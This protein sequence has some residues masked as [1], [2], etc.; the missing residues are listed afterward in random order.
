MGRS[1]GGTACFA[2]ST[3]GATATEAPPQREAPTPFPKDKL[4]KPEMERL[5]R[6]LPNEGE[7]VAEEDVEEL[8]EAMEDL[9]Y[10][11]ETDQQWVR[12]PMRIADARKN[13]YNFGLY[14]FTRGLL[15]VMAQSEEPD[16][17]EVAVDL[18][19][20]LL[21]DGVTQTRLEI[22]FVCE[23]N[24]IP[25]LAK[26]A[27]ETM[28]QSAIESLDRIISNGPPQV[29]PSV[30]KAGVIDIGIDVIQSQGRSLPMAHLAALDMLVKLAQRTPSLCVQ[31]GL[32]EAVKIVANPAM[33]PRRHRI[34]NLLRPLVDHEGDEAPTTNIRIHGIKW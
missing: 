31:A 26:I 15:R 25:V 4:F 27:R 12:F 3:E 32:Y 22:G 18:F 8:A 30:V 10:L 17:R 20:S 2:G 34:M 5:L 9:Q 33:A 28:S 6:M 11:H 23:C 14:K 29:V 21:H 16:L 19:H 1:S 13:A 7:Q 24:A